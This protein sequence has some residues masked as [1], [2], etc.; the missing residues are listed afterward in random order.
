MSGR[1]RRPSSAIALTVLISTLARRVRDA[2]LTAYL[3]IPMWLL[4]PPV[5]L[6]VGTWLGGAAYFWIKPLNDWLVDMTPSG[7]WVRSWFY[8]GLTAPLMLAQFVWMVGLQLAGAALFLLLAI[9]R[10][11]PTFRRQEE[12]TGRRRWSRSKGR[13]GDGRPIPNAVTIR[14]CGRSATSPRRIASPASCS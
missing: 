3:L 8:M 1:H 10:L 2:I 12:M 5:V 13:R 14:S 6:L 7:L 4:I 11:R 9:W